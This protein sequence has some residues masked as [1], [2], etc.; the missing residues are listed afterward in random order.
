M[1]DDKNESC[2]VSDMFTGH[3]VVVRCSVSA[4]SATTR[5]YV[6]VKTEKSIHDEH[7]SAV[8]PAT[9]DRNGLVGVTRSTNM[10]YTASVAAAAVRM[11]GGAAGATP[12]PLQQSEVQRGKAERQQWFALMSGCVLL[13]SVNV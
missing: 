3:W 6:R 11:N 1:N 2:V 10:H 8:V 13:G 4:A 5:P 12:T 7:L 9:A